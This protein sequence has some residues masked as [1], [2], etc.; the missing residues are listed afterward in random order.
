MLDSRTVIW[1]INKMQRKAY[2]MM[3]YIILVYLCQEDSK[4]LWGEIQVYDKLL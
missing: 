3:E 2:F 1:E 4:S